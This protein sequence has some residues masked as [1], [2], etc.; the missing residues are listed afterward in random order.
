MLGE[1]NKKCE[2]SSDL[3]EEDNT[4]V[5]AAASSFRSP[6]MGRLRKTSAFSLILFSLM[7]EA[8]LYV[9]LSGHTEWCVTLHSYEVQP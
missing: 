6:D 4:D 9:T 3:L 1:G 8:I 2:P 5:V 7:D